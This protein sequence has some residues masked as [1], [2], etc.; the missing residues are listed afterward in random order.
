VLTWLPIKPP[1]KDGAGGSAGSASGLAVLSGVGVGRSRGT[2]GKVVERRLLV[3][4]MVCL[5]YRWGADSVAALT[6]VL[7]EN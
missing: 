1:G 2:G 5:A 6:Q 7:R 3:T 4:V